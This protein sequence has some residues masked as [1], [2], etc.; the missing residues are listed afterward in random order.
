MGGDCFALGKVQFEVPLEN[1]LGEQS[2]LWARRTGGKDVGVL[3]RQ[4]VSEVQESGAYASCGG[5]PE[6][7]EG[8]VTESKEGLH[9]TRRKVKSLRTGGKLGLKLGEQRVKEVREECFLIA[10]VSKEP[11]FFENEVR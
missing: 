7:A 10:N 4:V 9:S 2:S 8:Q 6:Q 3:K 5:N 1:S 11:S